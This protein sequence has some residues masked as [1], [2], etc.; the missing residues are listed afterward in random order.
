M[1]VYI[2]LRS[3]FPESPEIT[4]VRF[5]SDKTVGWGKN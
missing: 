2:L 3:I 1:N 5:M 4:K